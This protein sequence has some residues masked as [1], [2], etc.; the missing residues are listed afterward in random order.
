MAVFLTLVKRG[1]Y[2]DRQGQVTINVD[3]IVSMEWDDDLRQT[4]LTMSFGR[5]FCVAEGPQ[6][7]A[8]MIRDAREEARDV[9]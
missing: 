3:N 1:M 4:E 6:R 5:S 9:N 2:Q 8:R 7:L